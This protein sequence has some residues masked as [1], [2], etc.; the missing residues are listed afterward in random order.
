ME[1]FKEL[2]KGKN[3]E[4]ENETS[5]YWEEK[6]ILN[7]SIQN[8]KDD[9]VFYDGPATAN[10]MP[11][12]HHMMAKLLKDTV[13]KYKTMKG[14]R[15][16]R[17]VGWDTHGLPVEVQVEKE[18][19]FE[20]KNDIE[21][22]G[23]QKF[24]EKCRESVW[25]NEK[26][27]RDFT[28]EMGQFID[29]KNPYITYENNYI[30][31]EWW[32]L[33]K[34]FD[35]GYIYDGLKILPYCPRCGT[36]LASHEVAQGYKEVSVNTVTVPLKLKNKEN[37]YLL[38]W[39]TTPWTLIA[40]VAACVNPN[41]EYVE[42]LSKGYHFIVAK[43]LADKVLGDNYEVVETYKGTDLE[44]LE[45]EQLLPFI[46]TNKKAFFVTC[47]DYVT[48]EDGT[49]IVHIA[50]AFGADDY[51]VGLKYDLPMIN[52]VD[53][54]GCYTEG[55]WKGR[56]VVDS[57]LE[58]DIIKYLAGE[59]KLFKKQKMVHNYPHC[60]RCKTPLV[61][62]SKPSLYIK[63]TAI[64][65]KIVEQNNTVNWYPSYVGE[66]RFGNWLENMNDWAISRNRYW[67]TPI[68]LWKCSCGHQE[69]IGSRVELVEKA[70]EK[71]DETIELHR[72][73][74]DDIHITC[75]E[76]GKEMTRIKDVIDCWFD[77]G[78]MPFAQ[79]HYPFENKELFESQFPADFI[80][81]GIDQTRGWF[82][83]L[84]VISTFVT[85]KTPY[86][87]V[88]VNDLLLDKFGH[89]MHKSRGNA[90]NPF[91]LMEKFGADPIRF[92]MLYASPVW[93]PLKFDEDGVKEVQSKFFNTLKNTYTFFQM[94][95]NTDEVDPKS[96]HVDYK[97][98]EEID[99]WLLS[100]YHK[101]I[102][103]VTESMDEYDLNKAVRAINNFVNEDLSN[104]YIRRNR[105]RFWESELTIS[106]KAVYGTT[107]E[108]LLGICKLAAPFIPFVTEEIY[109]ALTDKESIHLEDYPICDEAMIDEK[110][111]K[112]MDLVRDLISLGRY[113]REEAKIKV[114]QPISEALID[115][116]NKDLIND[117]TLLIKEEL[118]VKEVV[119]TNELSHYMNYIV[120]PNFKTVGKILGPK[121]GEF[122]NVLSS[123]SVE[124]INK[125]QNNETITATLSGETFEV[126]SEMIDIRIESKEGFN[127]GML[128]NNFIILNTELNEALIEEGIARELVSKIQQLRKSSDFEITDRIEVSYQADE[129]VEKAIANNLEYMKEETLALTITSKE[130]LK[131]KFDINGHEVYLEVIRK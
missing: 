18:L 101:L 33:K 86:K 65:D 62:Y 35:E 79:Y 124:E 21:K 37:T 6:D 61:Y 38:V 72:P 75:K 73:Y 123:L 15:V 19:G 41:E 103:F 5:Q 115:G 95:A 58:V 117:L 96:Y 12:I 97:D 129:E 29:L 51:E 77:S 53:E 39:T 7:K 110:I 119:F 25:K 99:K 64:K 122:G 92:Y 54:N 71:I 89:K 107:Y 45:Y 49:G 27:F 31:T 112:R 108:V 105:R 106:K 114:R 57:E 23:I 100:K 3:R 48:M 59:D 42:C 81:E 67:G 85:G 78:S 121:V 69:M 63:T 74:V 113:V 22:Y 80:S 116:K 4:L 26:A 98:L 130:N 28:T 84:L 91:E 34:L 87:N 17:K 66:K 16:L 93:T 55:P 32:I 14:Y 88:L 126:T 47:A 118:N 50:P 94:Y 104:W 131:D 76:C 83:S 43:K 111:E 1:K 8:R 56:L 30:E 20:G 60:W 13:C 40:N 44:H 10:G 70:I 125:L 90:I 109:R 9:F 68:P 52:P 128:N 120:K 102:K 24:N 2:K 36:G 46:E 11:G 127:V 82:Y